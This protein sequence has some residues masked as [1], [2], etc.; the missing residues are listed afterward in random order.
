[1]FFKNLTVTF[2]PISILHSYYGKS[3]LQIRDKALIN[4]TKFAIYFEKRS[5]CMSKTNWCHH[6]TQDL[7]HQKQTEDH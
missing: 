1:M 5:L 3:I 4:L 2:N 6:Q 7:T